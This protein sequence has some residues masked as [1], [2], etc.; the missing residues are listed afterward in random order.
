MLNDEELEKILTAGRLA[1]A[2]EAGYVLLRLPL[3]L[4]DLFR[5]WLHTHEPLKAERVLHRIFDARGGKAYDSTFGTRMT[6]TGSY[7]GLLGQRFRLAYKRLAFPGAPDFN[8]SL[9]RPPSAGGQMDL[10]S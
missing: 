1:G 4:H 5:E 7:A 9:F 8:L 3:E 6:G 10:F 2:I